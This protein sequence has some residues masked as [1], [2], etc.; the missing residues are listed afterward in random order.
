M[1]DHPEG[2]RGTPCSPV[3]AS[4]RPSTDS[5]RLVGGSTRTEG[6]CGDLG[7]RVSPTA[8]CPVCGRRRRPLGPVVTEPEPTA[9]EEEEDGGEEEVEEEQSPPDREVPRLVDEQVTTPSCPTPLR[10]VSHPLV[11][12]EG[13][14]CTR[15]VGV[16]SREH[17]TGENSVG[18]GVGSED[19]SLR[20][21][22]PRQRNIT[23][24]GSSLRP[25]SLGEGP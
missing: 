8:T 17:G 13:S 2:W 14:P 3:S 11:R 18:G 1:Y 25:V 4:P 22:R 7:R 9:A 10:P 24:V 23:L 12:R 16:P 19:T 21:F 6:V 20:W 15:R 5:V